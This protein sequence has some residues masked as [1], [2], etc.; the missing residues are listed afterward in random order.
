[1]RLA[2]RAVVAAACLCA[3]LLL[4]GCWDRIEVNDLAIVHGLALDKGENG[5]V[6]VTV[7][8]AVP[9][10][11]T[12][13]GAPG[14]GG[15]GPP[16]TNKSE[17]GRTVYEAHERLQKMLSRQLFWAHNAVILIGQ[18]LA[19]EG[20]SEVLDFFTR[21]RQPRLSTIFAVTEGRA[22]DVLATTLP[23]EL[24]VPAGIQEIER[25]RVAPFV[26]LR[27]FLTR[28]L[29]DG[30]EPFAGLVHVTT[31]GAP[32]PG[33]IG[34]ASPAA[35]AQAGPKQ[36]TMKGAAVFKGSR[37]VSLL[38]DIEV[39]GLLWILG[40]YN[41]ISINVPI[42]EGKWVAFYVIRQSRRLTPRVENGRLVMRVEVQVQTTLIDNQAGIDAD[43]LTVIR[44]LE[45]LLARNIEGTIR[46]T[47]RKVQQD[48]Q[49][50][51]FGFG[52]EVKRS[53]PN[54]WDQVRDAWDELFP[55]LPVEVHV[56]AKILRTGLTSRSVTVLRS[57][58]ISGARLQEILNQ[59]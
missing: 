4:S 15:Q 52:A 25:L 30:V 58:T 11:I 14:G 49:S 48:A 41:L 57:E 2:A 17:S 19:R 20:V 16:A 42:E 43:D 5:Q 54:A 18:D 50:D 46:Q 8:I 6:E 27:T 3:A 7:S 51:I 55:K 36:P 21:S 44:R 32:E 39:H 24:N 40:E 47:L 34:T 45:E 9:A 35:Q 23:I 38:S 1:M 33:A 56:D 31:T 13:P 37:L 12:P 53:L 10:Q 28:L 59:E 29:N 26:T 22:K